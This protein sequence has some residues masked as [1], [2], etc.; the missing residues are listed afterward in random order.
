MIVR[1][2][3]G[4]LDDPFTVVRLDSADIAGDTRR[5]ADEAYT[6]SLTG[7]RRAVWLRLEGP[8]N[9]VPAL[10]PLFAAPPR[11]SVV[12]VEAGDLR[13]GHAV[14]KLFEGSGAAVAIACYG[15]EARDVERLARETLE[16][17]GLA[18][19]ADARQAL[20]LL[21][22]A[23]RGA[24]R[25]ELEKL[26][27]YCQGTGRVILA[28]VEAVIGDA[29]ALQIDAVIDAVAEGRLPAADTG[30]MRLHA[31]G[32]PVAT[33]MTALL[34]HFQ[35]LLALRIAVDRGSGIDAAVEGLR[36]RV[37][38]R[39]KPSLTAQLRA[40]SQA[41]IVRALSRIE[42]A[43]VQTR[44]LPALGEALLGTLFIMLAGRAR[45]TA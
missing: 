24:T 23:D 18:L 22:G 33:L 42:E 25:A 35:M 11:D 44:L 37:H 29:S 40:W 31:A 4:S 19:D 7:G 27:L 39:R 16:A 45:R 36:P 21:L 15:D 13:P 3:A 28:D 8:R 26:A 43:L 41:D 17:A 38:F 34:R 10:E 6:I 1:A 20:A 14:R 5:L 30:R 32:I 2:V 9:V 12:V